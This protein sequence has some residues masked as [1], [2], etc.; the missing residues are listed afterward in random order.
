MPI[1]KIATASR[2]FLRT[3]VSVLFLSAIAGLVLT[4]AFGFEEPNDRLQPI[5]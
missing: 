4:A 3:F 5:S 2:A 1:L